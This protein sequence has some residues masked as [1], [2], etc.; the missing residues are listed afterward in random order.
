MGVDG[1]GGER[2]G[3]F[4]AGVLVE[5]MSQGIF[6]ASWWNGGGGGI[7]LSDDQVGNL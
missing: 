1:S 3:G 2:M 4:C 7:L 5:V 6:I